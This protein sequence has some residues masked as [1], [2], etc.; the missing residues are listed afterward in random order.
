VRD[1]ARKLL[2]KAGHRV[3]LVNP[4]VG[5][6]DR[7]HPL[8]DSAS[9]V[10]S[11]TAAVDVLQVFVRDTADL[12]KL[13][14]KVFQRVKPDGVL[15]VCCPKGRTKAPIDLNRD[16]LWKAMEKNGLVGVTL[17]AIDDTWSA[18]RFRPPDRV[19]R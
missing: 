12:H 3:G 13:D 5:Y 15:W 17:V 2:I 18:M 4:P 14:P 6:L 10:K 7:L 1:V 11:T 9:V 8:P 16:V 19:G